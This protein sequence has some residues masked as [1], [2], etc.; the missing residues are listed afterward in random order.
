V[1]PDRARVGIC[2]SGTDSSAPM[3]PSTERSSRPGGSPV[4][5]TASGCSTRAV[6]RLR[7]ALEQR[8]SRSS[9]L[10]GTKAGCLEAPRESSSTLR[11][12]GVGQRRGRGR[13]ISPRCRR[14]RRDVS[15]KA[16]GR[17]ACEGPSSIATA[18][19]EPRAGDDWARRRPVRGV[20]PC[21]R[22]GRTEKPAR[23][24]DLSNGRPFELGAAKAAP[25]G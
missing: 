1:E 22:Y 4:G 15:W 19:S 14:A 17:R 10:G 9:C 20:L 5:S 12:S 3:T 8:P 21:G 18:R 13:S 11:A 7:P 24:R 6:A 16:T 25:P 23:R 2:S